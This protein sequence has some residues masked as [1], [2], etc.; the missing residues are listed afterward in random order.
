[1]TPE[2]IKTALEDLPGW[3]LVEVDQML[4]LEKAY[5]F[6]DFAEALAFTNQVGALAEK[7]DHH[8]ALLTEWG[9]VT[10]NWWSHS[11]KGVTEND[12]KLAAMVEELTRIDPD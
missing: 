9:K 10:L 2:E 8:P 4:Q 6:K 7:E 1:M 12:L 5:S 3:K 11:T